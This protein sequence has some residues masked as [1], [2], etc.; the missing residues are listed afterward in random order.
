MRSATIEGLIR[1]VRFGTNPG[2]GIRAVLEGD[3]FQA[4]RRLDSYNWEHLDDIVDVVQHTLPQASYGSRE[5]VKA[6]ME[7]SDSEREAMASVIQHT[8]QMLNNRLQDILDLE[9][10]EAA[11]AR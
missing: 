5:I 9:E 4:K 3:L 10:A 2:S 6:W 8:L 11:S 1:Y 7:M